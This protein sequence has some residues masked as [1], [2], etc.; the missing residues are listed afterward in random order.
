MV[1]IDTFAKIRPHKKSNESLYER[2]YRDLEGLQGLAGQYGLAIVVVHHQ[3]K[4]KSEDP[5]DTVSGSTGITGAADTVWILEKTAR[6]EADGTLFI[7]GRDIEE[8]TG[9]MKF[10]KTTGLWRWMGDAV[11]LNMSKERL[12]IRDVLQGAEGPLSI[13]EISEIIRKPYDATNK[14]IQRMLEKGEVEKAAGNRGKY[15]LPAE[16]QRYGEG[17]KAESSQA[18]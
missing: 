14:R 7:S 1:A 11:E 15:R 6:G 4:E 10:D 3:R 9:A 12:E 2:D 18:A 5:Y 13:K 17:R 16:D 8:R